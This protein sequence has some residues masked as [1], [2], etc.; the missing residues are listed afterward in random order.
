MGN[1]SPNTPKRRKIFWMLSVLP[2]AFLYPFPK[3]RLLNHIAVFGKMTIGRG[4]VNFFG[5]A[6]APYRQNWSIETL[7]GN[8]YC[9]YNEDVKFQEIERI[10]LN[11]GC[12]LKR[13]RAHTISMFILQSRAK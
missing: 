1:S 4:A 10:I 2:A 12:A 7:I 8:A 3:N 6:A 13:L 11:D 5:G 9:A